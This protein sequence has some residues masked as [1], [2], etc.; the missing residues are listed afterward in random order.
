M[1]YDN[2][3]N[4]IYSNYIYFKMFMNNQKGSYGMFSKTGKQTLEKFQI[5]LKKDEIINGFN[6]KMKINDLYTPDELNNLDTQEDEFKKYTQ[7]QKEKIENSENAL[8]RFKAKSKTNIIQETKRKKIIKEKNKHENPPC[9]K[10]NPN[11]QYCAKKLIWG[12]KWDK[13]KERD[14]KINLNKYDYENKNEIDINHK[15]NQSISPILMN[16]FIDFNKQLYRKNS[17]EHKIK[18]S[19]NKYKESL[20]NS[21]FNIS[22]SS[23]KKSNRK[24]NSIIQLKVKQKNKAPDFRKGISR[25]YLDKLQDLKKTVIPFFH[26]NYSS[27]W[28]S[29]YY[30][31]MYYFIKNRN[32][33]LNMKR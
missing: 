22:D 14:F 8:N 24:K 11:W 3:I 16:T 19:E 12:V 29:K 26:P 9:N 1:I 15:K 6:R 2:Y 27:I 28:G 30:Y 4:N 17:H 21:V 20:N 7:E 25:A 13:M 10:Y 33:W 18:K 5:L 31:L 32:I 23:G